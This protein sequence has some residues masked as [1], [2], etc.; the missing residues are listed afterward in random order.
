MDCD[1][2]FT[3]LTSRPFPSG[4]PEDSLIEC[5]LIDCESCRQIAEALR[6]CDHVE[7][8]SLTAA[9][10][11]SLPRY[12][13][14][15]RHAERSPVSAAPSAMEARLLAPPRPR[16]SAS[17]AVSQPCYLPSGRARQAEQ[18][19]AFSLAPPRQR[20]RIAEAISLT[21]LASLVALGGWGLGWLTM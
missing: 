1:R 13:S 17:V 14:G 12:H 20:S 2:V 21:A 10:R 15:Q 8:E 5:H 18:L 19:A 9:E 4:S 11:R 6:P 3:V 7:H 16:P